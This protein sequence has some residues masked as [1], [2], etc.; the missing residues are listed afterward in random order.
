MVFSNKE[1]VAVVSAVDVQPD[2]AP[3]KVTP[4]L[5]VERDLERIREEEI[6]LWRQVADYYLCTV[7]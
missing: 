4:I 2:V 7:G 5:G 3:D 6:T 1:Y